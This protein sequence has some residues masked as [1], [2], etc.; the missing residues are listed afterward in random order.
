MV[1]ILSFEV[2]SMWSG[3]KAPWGPPHQDPFLASEPC[4]FLSFATKPI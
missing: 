2:R 3:N 4:I 1:L